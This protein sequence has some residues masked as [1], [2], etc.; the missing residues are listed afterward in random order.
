MNGQNQKMKADALAQVP[1]L[2]TRP[3]LRKACGNVSPVIVARNA[4]AKMAKD[5]AYPGS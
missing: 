2:G 1:D 5:V 4:A 3:Y